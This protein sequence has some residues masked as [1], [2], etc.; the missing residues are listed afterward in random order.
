VSDADR[1]TFERRP[2][3]VLTVADRERLLEL[4]NTSPEGESSAAR[5]LREELDRAEIARGQVSV[6]TLVTMGSTVKFIDHDALCIRELR[7]VYPEQAN[8][9]RCISVLTLIG[10]ALIGLGP[11]QSIDLV[12]DGIGRRFTVLEVRST[13]G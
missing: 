9:N 11:G 1:A 4:L 10:S 13:S 5:F 3:I 2:P 6:T 8:D 12:E 7:L